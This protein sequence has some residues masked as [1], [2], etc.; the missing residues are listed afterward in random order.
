MT[1]IPAMDALFRANEVGM[2]A[3]GLRRRVELL[4]RALAEAKRELAHYK[5]LWQ[6]ANDELE[7]EK[8]AHLGVKMELAERDAAMKE[9]TSTREDATRDARPRDYDTPRKPQ[10]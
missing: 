4:E 1:D 8:T 3:E 6:R 9:T 5:S 10:S 7:A 2:D